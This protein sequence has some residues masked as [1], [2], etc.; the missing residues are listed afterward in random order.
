MKMAKKIINVEGDAEDFEKLLAI[1]ESV[2]ETL[3]F[4][5]EE[6]KTLNEFITGIREKLAEP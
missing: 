4:D 2:I 5:V 1:L 3:Q 6:Q